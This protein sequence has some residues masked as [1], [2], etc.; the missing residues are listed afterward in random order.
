MRFIKTTA[1]LAAA[2]VTV[3][4]SFPVFAQE[5]KTPETATKADVTNYAIITHDMGIFPIASTLD[6]LQLGNVSF[7]ESIEY[8][9]DGDGVVEKETHFLYDGAQRMIASVGLINEETKAEIPTEIAYDGNSLLPSKI[10]YFPA[11]AQQRTEDITFTTDADGNVTSFEM[12]SPKLMDTGLSA[13]KIA[14]QYN[15]AGQIIASSICEQGT[16]GSTLEDHLDTTAV[17]SYDADGC[18]VT[19]NYADGRQ[20]TYERD[21]NENMTAIRVQANGKTEVNKI[22]YDE[23]GRISR[24]SEANGGFIVFHY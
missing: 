3:A 14:Y 11:S 24:I 8:E 7:P 4:A 1:V 6:D 23:N 12:V 13:K 2:M 5:L 18:L 16:A 17:Y 21:A 9:L 20:V 15:E 10:V 19:V 22:S